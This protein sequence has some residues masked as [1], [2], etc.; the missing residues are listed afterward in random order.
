VSSEDLRLDNPMLVTWEFASEERLE[1]RNAIVQQLIEG[2]N[3]EELLFEAIKEFAP[4]TML[5]VGCGTGRLSARV[6]D[7]LGAEVRALDT[8]ERMVHLTRERGI[9][10]EVA[11]VQ[12]L[13]FEDG[14]FDCVAAGWVL[15][16]VPDRERAISECARVLRP[17]GRFVTATL[18]DDNMSDL[19]DYLGSPRE[20]QL[21]FCTTNGAAQLEPYFARVE[22]REAEGLIAFRSPE[23]MRQFV[24]AN[25]VRAHLAATVP[26][27]TEP[28][29]VRTHH[30]VF[31]ADKA[32]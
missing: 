13:P 31:V 24:A 27:F 23:D 20:R 3:P 15:Y 4:Q 1:K 29:P 6:R 7:E 9:S 18:A 32:A 25:M 12:A 17:G 19:W 16:H 8:S 22:A 14:T 30:T 26:D 5:E 10:A 2:V 11:D 21:T 28:V